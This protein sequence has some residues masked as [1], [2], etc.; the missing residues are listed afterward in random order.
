MGHT[1]LVAAGRHQHGRSGREVVTADR[2]RLVGLTGHVGEVSWPTSP[3]GTGPPS[4]GWSVGEVP[5]GVDIAEPLE[6]IPAH[7]GAFVPA[8]VTRSLASRS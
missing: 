2:K 6:Q 5:D 8:C 7:S 4:S 3:S 1:P